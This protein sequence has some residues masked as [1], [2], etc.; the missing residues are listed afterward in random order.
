MEKLWLSKLNRTHFSLLKT[1]ILKEFDGETSKD[2]A[3]HMKY[4]K[5]ISE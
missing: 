3:L 2:I 1:Q 4:A 5:L